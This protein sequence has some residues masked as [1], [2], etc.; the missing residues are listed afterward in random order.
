MLVDQQDVLGRLRT[1]AHSLLELI[2]ATLEV[3][4]IEAGRCGVRG[5]PRLTG[6]LS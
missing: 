5:W 2:N 6:E 3:N 1:N 4:C